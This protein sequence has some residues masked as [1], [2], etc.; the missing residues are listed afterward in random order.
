M[1]RRKLI[2]HIIA[3]YLICDGVADISLGVG[4]VAAEAKGPDWRWERLVAVLFGALL[5]QY[6]EKLEACTKSKNE[7]QK[8]ELRRLMVTTAFKMW[9]N[10]RNSNVTEVDSL[11]KT[12]ISTVARWVGDS[13]DSRLSDPLSWLSRNWE[14]PLS[15]SDSEWRIPEGRLSR[16]DYDVLRVAFDQFRKGS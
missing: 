7:P 6:N 14:K 4:A 5:A 13:A 8:E 11:V 10:C 12:H 9:V 2:R 15:L 1:K 16:D 3:P